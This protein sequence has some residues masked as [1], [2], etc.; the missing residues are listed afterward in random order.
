MN[1][2]LK[3]LTY[4]DPNGRMQLLEVLHTLV[5]KMPL[6]K[7]ETYADLVF[8]TLFVRLVNEDSTKCREKCSVVIGVLVGKSSKRFVD[9]VLQMESDSAVLVNGKLQMLALFGSMGKLTKQ[10]IPRVIDLVDG[11]VS[12]NA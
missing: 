2:L 9:T 5:D 1:H 7:L 3:N 8:L 12:E 11:I 6:P 10:D 4:F